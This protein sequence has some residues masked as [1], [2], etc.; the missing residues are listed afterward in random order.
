[1]TGIALQIA[2][3][4]GRCRRDLRRFTFTVKVPRCLA[5]PWGHDAM[6]TIGEVPEAEQ[7]VHGDNWPHDDLAWPKTCTACGYEFADDDEWQRNDNRLYRLP[8]GTEFAHWGSMKN[9]PAGTMIRIPHYDEFSQHPE[10]IESW[11]VILPD[12]GE[13]VT[14]QRAS[15]GG[16]WTV[17]GTPPLITVSPSIW[18]DQPNGWHGFIRNGELVDA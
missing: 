6:V 10:R 8:D 1:M 12:G 9:V 5:N 2:E 17:S 4:T 13:W 3:P 14:S 7:A 15:G 16:F 11:L 18:H